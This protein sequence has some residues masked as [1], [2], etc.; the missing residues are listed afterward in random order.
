MDKLVDEVSIKQGRA[1]IRLTNAFVRNK[2]SEFK[3][4]HTQRV[5][6]GPHD[7]PFRLVVADIYTFGMQLHLVNG[8]QLPIGQGISLVSRPSKT[9][10][11]VGA[12][13]QAVA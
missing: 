10:Q 2:E 7:G 11:Q 3:P 4:V 12:T 8:K 1:H 5:G 13:R 6:I 9:K